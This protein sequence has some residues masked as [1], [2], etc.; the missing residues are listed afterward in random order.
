MVQQTQSGRTGRTGPARVFLGADLGASSGRVVAGQF[1]DDRLELSEVYRFDNGPVH[2]LDR[3]YWDFYRQWSEVQ[4]GLGMAAHQFGN[5]IESIGVDTW[6][7]DFGLVGPGQELL[8]NPRHY[9]D[10]RTR[11]SLDRTFRE[12]S[13]DEIFDATG[14]QF[15]ELNTL[16]QLLAIRD[17]APRLLEDAERFLMMPDL[18]HWHLTGTMSN[19]YTNASTTQLLDPHTRKWSDSLLARL[20]IPSHPF[21]EISAPGSRLGH[22]HTMVAEQLGLPPTTQVIL[23]GTHDTASAVLAVPASPS[24]TVS[25]RWCYISSGTWSLMGVEVPDP[26]VNQRCRELNFT[27]E[28][29]VAG[30]VRL[31]RNIA[32]LWLVQECRR[33]WE[34]Q[35]R[36]YNWSQLTQLATAAPRLARIINP[37]HPRL[38]APANM[39]QAI[40]DLCRESGQPAPTSD[41]DIVRCALES[42]ALRY[43]IVLGWLEELIGGTIDTVHIVGGGTQNQLLCQMAADAC[44]RRVVAGPVEATAL[45][46]LAMQMVAR[47]AVS[48]ITEARELIRHSFPVQEYEPRDSDAWSDAL[49]KHRHQF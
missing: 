28:G 38:V 18:F 44:Q 23:P 36:S 13:R 5:A 17:E 14:L 49:A 34:A 6:G 42:L 40:A 15:M 26:V 11:G 4:H 9:R 2:I 30:T 25:Q 45:G 21:H 41:G 22:V 29:G 1:H 31:L 3:M 27:N 10:K 39:P 32:G 46:N 35:G 12:V 24:D 37:D 16:Y 20:R 8:G 47:G 43:R 7:V 48:S 33:I 19:E